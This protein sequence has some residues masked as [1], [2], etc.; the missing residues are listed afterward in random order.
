MAESGRL[1]DIVRQ[2]IEEIWNKSNFTVTNEIIAAD[3]IRHEATEDIQG[4]ENFREFVTAFRTAFPDA[5]FKIDD[6][7]VDS[8]SVAIRY[9][10][11]G[12]HKRRYLEISP[13]GNQVTATG[14]SISRIAAGKIKET[15]NYIDKLSILVQLGWWVPAK[16][17]LLAYTW[18]KEAETVATTPGDRKKNLAIVRRGLEELWNTGNLAI[19][20]EVYATNF[21]NHEITHRQYRDLESYKKYV[22]AIHSVM[23]GFG[24]DIKDIIA[25]GN[26]VAARWT[27]SGTEKRTGNYYSWGGITIFRL[28]GGKITE[29]WW[30][31][32]AVSIAQQMGLAPT[33]RK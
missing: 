6:L 27:V 30:S 10:F 17:W 33:F 11:S 12:T 23:S 13:T 18:G 15:W 28:T 3:C 8:K 24:V 20:D 19:A 25:D 21:L 31:R 29:A 16:S 5:H 2:E 7:I 22:T 9:T 32:D 1:K 4:L 14:M 26:K